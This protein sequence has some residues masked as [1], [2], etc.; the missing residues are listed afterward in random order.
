MLASH[1]V[2]NIPIVCKPRGD[3]LFGGG[4]M[5]KHGDDS[6]GA[7]EWWALALIPCENMNNMDI[8]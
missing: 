2:G 1:C 4:A 8:G 6:S 3:H 7:V 5:L